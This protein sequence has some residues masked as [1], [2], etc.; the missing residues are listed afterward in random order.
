MKKHGIT[1][2]I[3]NIPLDEDD[4]VELG[5]GVGQGDNSGTGDESP[6]IGHED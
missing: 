3:P 4:K 2:D 1:D 6:A 5:D